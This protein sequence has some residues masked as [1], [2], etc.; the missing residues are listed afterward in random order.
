MLQLKF[1]TSG[2]FSFSFV[3][4][5]LAYITTPKNKRKTKI[6]WDK[7]LTTT[8]TL[9]GYK[10]EGK[11]K[12][13]KIGFISCDLASSITSS[14]LG[15]ICPTGAK[16]GSSYWEF[17]EIE[18]LSPGV[19]EIGVEIIELEWG[20]SKGNKVWFEISGFHCNCWD[21]SMFSR[22]HFVDCIVSLKRVIGFQL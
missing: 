4:T 12:I 7:K 14:Y 18:G 20:K 9:H 2:N 21:S 5:S 17:W 16:I 8:Y 1:F 3:S 19:W 22:F 13:E 11:S 6:I 10:G 15:S